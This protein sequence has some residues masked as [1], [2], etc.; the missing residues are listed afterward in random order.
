MNKYYKQVPELPQLPSNLILT[1]DDIIAS[2]NICPTGNIKT[3][4]SIFAVYDASQAIYDMYEP[5]FENKVFIRWQ[6]ITAD[7]PVHYDWGNSE[8]KYLYLIDAG[9]EDVITKFWSG[10]DGDITS[11]GSFNHEGRSLELEV[12]EKP[13]TWH[14]LNVKT[15]H[16]VVNVVRT[17]IAL[18][19][20]PEY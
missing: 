18:I 6:V 10:Q 9:G 13:L 1:L 5:Y 11:G 2:G 8:L 20:R 4:E 15:P 7:L 14:Y 19:I 17:R 16:S 12:K 3:R